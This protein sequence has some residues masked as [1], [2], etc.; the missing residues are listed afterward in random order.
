MFWYQSLKPEACRGNRI[1]HTER[2]YPNRI[3]PEVCEQLLDRL[4]S[5]DYE[6]L[7]ITQ[8]WYRL[9]DN[10]EYYASMSS[11]HRIVKRAGQNGDRRP[12]HPA[13]TGTKRS[14]PVLEATGA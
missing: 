5:K 12:Q 7:S 10:G 14:K 9:L 13:G 8:A 1:P 3:E 6:D 2:A 4:N 11:T